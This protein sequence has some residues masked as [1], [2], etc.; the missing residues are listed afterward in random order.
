M[1]TLVNRIIWWLL[2]TAPVT[3]IQAIYAIRHSDD[4]QRVML[5]LFPAALLLSLAIAGGTIAWRKRALVDPIRSGEIDLST[6]E[7]LGRA[8]TPYVLNVVLS[9]AVAIFGVALSLR[10]NEPL[11][12]LGFSLASLALM[13]VHRP[14]AAELQYSTSS[15]SDGAESSR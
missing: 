5:D 4:P 8:F 2:C 6:P 3:Y 14:T 12:T 15:D 10:S 1:G 7:G 13:Y 11:Y 9:Q